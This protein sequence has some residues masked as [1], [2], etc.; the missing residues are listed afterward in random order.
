[1][2]PPATLEQGDRV[3]KLLV[4]LTLTASALV[5]AT[6]ASA[7]V[8]KPTADPPP[9]PVQAES[10]TV[11]AQSVPT[12]PDATVSQ[13]RPL[14]NIGNLPVDVWAPVEPPYDANMNRNQAANPV[15]EQG[16]L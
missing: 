12:N 13:P 3:M 11:T 9:R 6:T 2:Y 10:Q 4:T 8:K 16:G 15:F 7:Q 1:M 5:A 14:F